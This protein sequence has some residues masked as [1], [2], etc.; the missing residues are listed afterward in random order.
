MSR[1]HSHS[2]NGKN[3]NHRSASDILSGL[4]VRAN[5]IMTVSLTL[6]VASAV[7]GQSEDALLSQHL[8]FNAVCRCVGF[9]YRLKDQY[10]A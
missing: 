10:L 8:I 2:Y 3:P 7:L 4:L 6:V 5:G 9:S 1:R